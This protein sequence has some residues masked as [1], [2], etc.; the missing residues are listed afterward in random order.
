M[1]THVI[2]EV[3]I[4]LVSGKKVRRKES[5][6]GLILLALFGS[7]GA[8]QI[9][10]SRLQCHNQ[11]LHFTSHYEPHGMPRPEPRLKTC[12]PVSSCCC[13]LPSAPSMIE[14]GRALGGC[15]ARGENCAGST[16][17]VV[18][19]SAQAWDLL[20]SSKLQIFS[21]IDF[22]ENNFGRKHRP[23]QMSS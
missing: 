3:L 20:C 5:V 16:F 17:I 18:L 11:S 13:P 8:E 14:S 12:Q 4:V 10:T 6:P 15:A 22:T 9:F 21:K 2:T 19:P 7:T 1:T 23:K